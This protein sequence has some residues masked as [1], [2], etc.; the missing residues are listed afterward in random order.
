MKRV[1]PYCVSGEADK[2]ALEGFESEVIERLFALNAKRAEEERVKGIGKSEKKGK[3]VA[4]GEV[5]A[6]SAGKGKKAKG[7]KNE[8]LGLGDVAP[9]DTKQKR[10]TKT[11]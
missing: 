9:E 2:R 8:E 7:A 10:A 5:G 6:K 11:R 3:R 4:T 1:P